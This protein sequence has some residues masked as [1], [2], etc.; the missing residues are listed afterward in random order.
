MISQ[1]VEPLSLEN[2]APKIL[3]FYT[4]G[5]R[6]IQIIRMADM[7]EPS[8]ERV[9]FPG[10]RLLFEALP[11]AFL[12]ISTANLTATIVTKKIQCASIHVEEGLNVF[13][14]NMPSN[15]VEKV[16]SS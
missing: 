16:P 13:L 3:C 2:S 12:E 6:F 9:V 7:A 5:T 8:L 15:R 14:E 1:K 11:E 10:Q 4:N